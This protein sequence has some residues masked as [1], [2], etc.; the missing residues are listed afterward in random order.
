MHFIY[1]FNESWQE[2]P[3]LALGEQ[4]RLHEEKVMKCVSDNRFKA[5]VKSESFWCAM[6]ARMSLATTCISYCMV[7]TTQFHRYM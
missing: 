3:G 5:L 4:A 1:K 2:H 7:M 6:C